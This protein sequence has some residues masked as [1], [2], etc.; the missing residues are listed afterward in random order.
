MISK[1]IS[2]CV[3]RD[4]NT[5]TYINCFS[6]YRFLFLSFTANCVLLCQTDTCQMTSEYHQKEV[7]IPETKPLVSHNYDKSRLFSI[8]KT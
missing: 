2:V 7:I 5:C 1:Y 4:T 8:L 6:K 3:H